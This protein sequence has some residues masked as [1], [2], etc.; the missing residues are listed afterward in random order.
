MTEQKER[1]VSGRRSALLAVLAVATLAVGLARAT[2]AVTQTGQADGAR[3]A[4]ATESN[5]FI[6]YKN[7]HRTAEGD[8]IIDWKR[9]VSYWMV[10]CD[11]WIEKED[12]RVVVFKVWH[13]DTLL[14][15]TPKHGAAKP[16]TWSVRKMYP[17]DGRDL[18][19]RGAWRKTLEIEINVG[20]GRPQPL[21]THEKVC[22]ENLRGVPV[23]FVDAEARH[24]FT[25]DIAKFQRQPTIT[26]DKKGNVVR[27]YEYLATL[28]G[29]ETM[30]SFAKREWFFLLS[31]VAIG[32]TIAS[33]ALG[34]GIWLSRRTVHWLP[35]RQKREEDEH[36]DYV[37]MDSLPSND[38]GVEGGVIEDKG[39]TRCPGEQAE[40]DHEDEAAGP[41]RQPERPKG[42]ACGDLDE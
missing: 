16:G 19:V 23:S 17:I 29:I 32:I 7:K 3:N 1:H 10:K 8:E 25:L 15:E 35:Y 27:R 21:V 18:R 41:C 4:D 12:V 31:L 37:E 36:S 13:P 26:R 2:A 42:R 14:I 39:A 38:M 6:W 5:R 24:E 11:D 40:A 33:A 20:R 30:S 9:F 22:F 28:G 34:G